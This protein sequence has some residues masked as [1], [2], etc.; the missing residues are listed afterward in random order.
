MSLSTIRH[1]EVFPAHKHND[2]IDLIGAGAI[3]SRVW[4][5]LV[6]LGLT[7]MSVYDFDDVEQQQFYCQ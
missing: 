7:D 1:N 3:G 5:A 6:E 4:A 2:H